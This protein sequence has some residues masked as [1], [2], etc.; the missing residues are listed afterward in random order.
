METLL[1]D[2]R[3]GIRMLVKNPGF[4]IVAV[5]TMALG[6]GANTALFS[7]V[8]G[9]L[10]KSLPF[11]DPDR[12]VFAMETNAKFPPPGVGSS[13]L[14]YRDWKEQN[15]SFETLSA[16]Q[17][18]IA[19][20]TSSDQP[21]RIQGEKATWDYFTT[22]GI[23]P[24]AG[25]TF[26]AEE[27]RPGGVPVILLSEG[28]WRRR[29]GGDA[30]IVGQTIPINGQ[31]VTVIGIM[32][33]DYRPNI[34]FWMPLG[35]SYQN[36][37]RNLH[38]IQVVGRL[39]AGVTQEQAQTEMSTIAQRLIEQYPESNT[40]WG[41][42]L[43]PY[44]NLVTFNIRWALLVLLAAVG[45]V[46]LIACANVAN[47]LL[48]RAASREKEIAIRLAMGA[49]RGR[50][51]RQV[52]TESVLISLIGGAVGM[53]IALWSTQALISLNPQGIPRSGEIGVDGRVLGF[54]VLASLA[55]GIL[56][57]LVP[58][59]QSSRA[60][61]NETLKES[62]KSV[63]GH[64]RGRR[65]RSTLV[66]VQMAFAFMLLVCA[67]L[68]IKSFSQLQRV[69]MGFNQQHLLTMQVTL[70]PAQYA[71]PADVL[72]FYRDA[73]ERLGALPGVIAASGISN[74]PLAGGGPQFIFSVEGRPLPTPA[75][76]PIASYRIVT[77]DYFATMNIPL[78]RGRTFTD[79]D[80]ENS[81]Q[82]V[83]VNQNMAELM[84]PG[85]DAVG[86]RLTVGVPLPGD[87][88]DYATVVGVV[89][90]VK[91]TTLAG[92]TGMQIYQPVT[93]TP[94]LGLGFGRTMSF[95]LR[96][97][98]EPATLAES[99]RAVIAGI[100][101]RL[102]VANVKTMDTI[103][104]E[105]VAANRF[106]MSLFGLF[107]AIAMALTVVGIFGVMNYAVTQRTQEIGIRMALGAQPGQ[108]R[109]LILKQGLILSGLGLTI[110]MGGAL[111]ATWLL[112]SLLFS[113]S[114]TDPM[115]LGGVAV[116]LAAVALLTCYIPARRAT[117]VDP[118][119]ALRHE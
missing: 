22:L 75:D 32:P 46:L 52:L 38:N 47:L 118:I 29:F 39:A 33:N 55:A 53:L 64:G 96:T 9:V 85:E 92:E 65:L 112:K 79:A 105:S 104:A 41:V 90:N 94:F 97:Q 24:L 31:G 34:E 40:G 80:K 43:I 26:T 56:F 98:L 57:G 20:L 4:T 10:L 72:G 5:I 106:N 8:N 91:H 62:G 36:A 116:V 68:L 49:T 82:V 59:W 14:N 12:L 110:G 77:G 119:I 48:A 67:G 87:T 11:K 63:A 28:L 99:A 108:V 13:T 1:Q 102:P 107:A 18:F 115:V 78:I 76:A 7:V 21:E 15:Q 84:W 109:A 73:G 19:N 70:P 17:A 103:I 44:Q 113:V 50:L 35:I 83:T 16:R 117:K 100:N 71:R 89:G 86:K 88:P 58:A 93:Q 45:C 37:D 111:L 6:I 81:L 114:A 51:I 3:F 23:A 60:N 54:A 25:R 66:V 2:L 69:N 42:A 27:D 101:P 95:I 61:V 74:V 30:G